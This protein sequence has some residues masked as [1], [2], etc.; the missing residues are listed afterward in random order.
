MR[1]DKEVEEEKSSANRRAG[2]VEAFVKSAVRKEE[3]K[4]LP[5]KFP[6]KGVV[7]LKSVT[8][9]ELTKSAM[10]RFDMQGLENIFHPARDGQVEP[11][12]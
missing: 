5:C 9:A 2:P 8:T 11:S 1:T 12:D 7:E 10:A 6:K 4:T 3:S